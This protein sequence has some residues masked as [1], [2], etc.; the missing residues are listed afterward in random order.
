MSEFPDNELQLL[1]KKDKYAYEWVDDYRKFNY[2][3]VPPIDFFNSRLNSNKRGKGDGHIIK[4]E[5][6]HINNLW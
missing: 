6:N 5:H 4:E 1:K 2:P 3:R